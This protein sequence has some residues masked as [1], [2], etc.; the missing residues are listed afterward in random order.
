M[1]NWDKV[2]INNKRTSSL[3]LLVHVRKIFQNEMALDEL[4]QPL[5][6]K[7]N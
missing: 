2:I 7:L 6:E 3:D 5:T 1:W 4:V